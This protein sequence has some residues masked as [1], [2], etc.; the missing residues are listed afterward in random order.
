MTKQDKFNL[1]A[2]PVFIVTLLLAFLAAYLE[3]V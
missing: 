2:I 3:W 1:A